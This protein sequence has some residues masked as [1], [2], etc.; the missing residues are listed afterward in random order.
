MLIGLSS[1][2]LANKSIIKNLVPHVI[3]GWMI[4][5]SSTVC[6]F[7]FITKK[8]TGSAIILI[9]GKTCWNALQKKFDIKK[10][11]EINE[12]YDGII[13]VSLFSTLDR[14]YEMC[15]IWQMLRNHLYG[16]REI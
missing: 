13:E 4:S 2:P 14:P 6:L 9:N 3:V 10:Y 11:L 12:V 16:C 5:I 8:R 7:D 15:K 1:I